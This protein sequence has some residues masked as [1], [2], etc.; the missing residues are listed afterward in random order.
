MVL[1]ISIT[2]TMASNSR[3]LS[4]FHNTGAYISRKDVKSTVKQLFFNYVITLLCLPVVSGN[5]SYLYVKVC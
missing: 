4:G 2:R 3:L 1:F 5:T